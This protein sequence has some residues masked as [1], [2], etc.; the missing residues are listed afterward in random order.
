MSGH[1]VVLSTVGTEDEA[2][3]IASALVERRLAACVNVV[4]GVASTYR[5]QG[6]V[7]TDREWLQVI[8]TRRDRFEAVRTAIR[9][10]NTY[11]VPEIVMLDI[12]DGDEAYLAL[13]RRRLDGK[14]RRSLD[15]AAPGRCRDQIVGIFEP[16]EILTRP[17][18]TPSSPVFL[19]IAP[20]VIDRGCEISVSTPPGFPR[21]RRAQLSR[22]FFA[23]AASRD[24][25]RSSRRSRTSAL[26]QRV[27]RVRFQ[28]G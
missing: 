13:D 17:S 27:L 11:E 14:D 2:S 15:A 20:C 23:S 18:V 21:A 12:T 7:Q 28:P 22:N 6:A 4:S 19:G 3:R 9:E 26:R 8:K 5:W 1:A 25:T 16:T 10:L 24:R